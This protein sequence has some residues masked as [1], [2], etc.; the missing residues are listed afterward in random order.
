MLFV[1]SGPSGCGKS[2]LVRHVLETL[3]DVA[4]SVSHT[5]RPRRQGEEEGRDYHFITSEEFERFIGEDRF[6]EWAVVHGHYYGTAKSELERNPSRPRD[7]LLDIDVQGA[8]QIRS[9][10]RGGLFIF[11][12]PPSLAVLRERLE[13]RGKDSPDVIERRIAAAAAEIRDYSRFDYIIINDDLPSAQREL[14]SIILSERCR[15]A[16]R[17][18]AVIPIVRSF[19]ESE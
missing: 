2:T 3:P 1:V 17:R 18:E 9:R 4:F 6:V 11:I 16:E 13:S 12:L 19:A 10:H 5:T 14:V 7:L 15:L 8:R